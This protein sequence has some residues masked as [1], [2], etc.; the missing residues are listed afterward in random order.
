MA[1]DNLEELRSIPFI[2]PMLAAQAAMVIFR[3]TWHCKLM[4]IH[5]KALTKKH[6]PTGTPIQVNVGGVMITDEVLEESIRRAK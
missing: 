5:R 3:A 2:G 6:E 1:N 4:G